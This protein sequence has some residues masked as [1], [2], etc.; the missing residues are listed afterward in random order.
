MLT[1]KCQSDIFQSKQNG[2][3]VTDTKVDLKSLDFWFIADCLYSK[4]LQESKKRKEIIEF[5]GRARN[6]YRY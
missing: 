3:K 5:L 2:E 6:F 4:K 1:A